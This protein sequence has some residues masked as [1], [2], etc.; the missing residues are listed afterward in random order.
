MIHIQPFH[1]WQAEQ[2]IEEL[3]RLRIEVFR[4]F[5][6]LYDGDMDYETQYL[7]TLIDA[8]DN[9][10]VMAFNGSEVV[11][12]ATGLPLAHETFNI[13]QPI[14]QGGYN[15]DTIYYLGESIIRKPYRSNG[16]NTRF[17]QAAEHRAKSLGEYEFLAFCNI[18]RSPDHPASPEHYAEPR[19]HWCS[20]GFQPTDIICNISWK[21]LQESTASPK[22]LRFWIKSIDPR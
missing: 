13:S 19:K 21:D 5:P 7:K 14:E 3:A 2:Y 16:I 22:N 8:P 9:F 17:F 4:D 6:Y 10:I 20:L 15:I 12:A 18:E 1:G 11:G